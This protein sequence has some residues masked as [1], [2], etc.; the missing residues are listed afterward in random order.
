MWGCRMQSKKI[1]NK[2]IGSFHLKKQSNSTSTQKIVL[3]CLVF[4]IIICA[5]LCVY[6]FWYQNTSKIIT[7][8]FNNL[9][10]SKTVLYNGNIS[11]NYE[12]NNFSLKIDGM[13]N[14]KQQGK[15]DVDTVLTRNNKSYNFLAKATSDEN[16]DVYANISNISD[17]IEFISEN[18]NTGSSSDF[19][20]V[21]IITS[22]INNKWIK[23]SNSD[24]SGVNNNYSS[25][26]TCSISNV[27]LFKS[28]KKYQSEVNEV[29][30]NNQF[31]VFEKRIKNSND[32][33]GYQ[34]KIDTN[35]YNA[36]V[37]K[38]KKTGMYERLTA[39]NN[40]YE[41]PDANNISNDNNLTVSIWINKWSHQLSSIMLNYKKNNADLTLNLNFIFNKTN[42]VTLPDNYMTI[43]Q[44]KSDFE[45]ALTKYYLSKMNS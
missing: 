43:D 32:S 9:L 17:L 21:R 33:Y 18:N 35:K 5:L 41:L 16:G 2:S 36:F 19:G 4:I 27:N 29:F 42:K 8:A 15:L 37:A 38:F 31:I 30:K 39:C 13:T 10:S 1:K 44:V 34:I 25:D 22:D 6:K 23:I 26:Y 45:A 7:D 24:I 40:N 20:L 3:V 28:N 12:K 14:D 11:G